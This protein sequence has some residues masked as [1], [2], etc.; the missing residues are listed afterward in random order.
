MLQIASP[1]VVR[2]VQRIQAITIAWMSVELVSFF[3]AWRTQ[4]PALLAFGG[5]SAIKLFS[6]VVVMW[7]FVKSL[8]TK[9]R[10]KYPAVRAPKEDGTLARS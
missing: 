3:A 5:D 1:N 6:A 10:K 2:G 9:T 7:R 4:G 8:H